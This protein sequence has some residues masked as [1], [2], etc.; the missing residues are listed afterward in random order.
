MLETRSGWWIR[1]GNLGAV[2]GIK[3][4]EESNYIYEIHTHKCIFLYP[5][6]PI[7]IRVK[8]MKL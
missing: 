5:Y 4:L 8:F 2:D 6:I 1:K 3:R 7:N